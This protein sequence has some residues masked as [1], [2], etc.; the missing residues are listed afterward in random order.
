MN[1]SGSKLAKTADGRRVSSYKAAHWRK[2]PLTRNFKRYILTLLGSKQILELEAYKFVGVKQSN[3][4]YVKV[5]DLCNGCK[6]N[7]T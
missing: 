5:P 1:Y 2:I 4:N 6:P 7:F 3:S